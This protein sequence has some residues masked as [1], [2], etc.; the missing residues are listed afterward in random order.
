[1]VKKCTCEHKAQ[2]E[3]HGS[4]NRV[5]NLTQQGKPPEKIYRC[6]VCLK[7]RS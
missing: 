4:G 5:M 1:M 7:L 2:D 3:L 6:T